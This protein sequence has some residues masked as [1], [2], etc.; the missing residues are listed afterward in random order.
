MSMSVS[1]LPVRLSVTA[2]PG[3]RTP[4]SVPR[5]IVAAPTTAPVFPMLTAAPAAP[6]FV[7]PIIFAIDESGLP[8]RAVAGDSPMPI[9]WLAC[10]I[11]KPGS[12]PSAASRARITDS[13]PTRRIRACGIFQRPAGSHAASAPRRIASGA[14][15]PPITS[16]AMRAGAMSFGDR[17]AGVRSGGPR[18]ALSGGS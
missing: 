18:T 7:A 3:R 12:P 13:S 2:M 1:G 11:A 6:S 5:P 9:T 16:R 10:R 15:S 4:G 14:L 8:R 17:E